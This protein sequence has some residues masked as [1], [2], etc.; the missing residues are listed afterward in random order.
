[1]PT[2]NVARPRL[3][4]KGAATRQRLVD[5]AA[6][7]LRD[8]GAAS[9]TLDDICARTS[10][11]KS[12]IFHYFPG[13]KEELL[14][15]VAAREADQVLEDQQP[16]LADLTTWQA[17]ENWQQALLRRY[18]KQGINCPLGV[19][20]TEVGRN[21]PPHKPSPPA[22]STNGRQH[23]AGVESM[24]A[25]GQMN[26]GVSADR[27]AATLIATIQGGVTILISTGQI[28]YLET[29]LRTS[30]LLLRSAE[31]RE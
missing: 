19:L 8:L 2:N 5:G 29:A 7:V 13:G 31:N 22:C 10:T 1:M 25:T 18:K 23:S 9:T 17:W 3:T 6:A 28:T 12:Q 11:S 27:A 14:L 20:I 26:Q 30:L 15:A 16:H 21:T 24:Q 4:P